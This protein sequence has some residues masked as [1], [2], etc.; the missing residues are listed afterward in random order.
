MIKN[1]ISKRLSLYICILMSS[2]T[3]A[4]A[5][6]ADRPDKYS[7]CPDLPNCVLTQSTDK[8]RFIEPLHYV[9]II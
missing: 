3:Y 6:S 1:S 8:A 2:T 5:E 9:G 7:P 4:E